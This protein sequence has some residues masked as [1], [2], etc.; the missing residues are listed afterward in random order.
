MF[1]IVVPLFFVVNSCNMIMYPCYFRYG[2]ADETSS[3]G[4]GIRKGMVY[5][6]MDLKI[7]FGIRRLPCS[8]T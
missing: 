2:T 3:V 7:C 1:V 8:C 4:V 5:V 6:G